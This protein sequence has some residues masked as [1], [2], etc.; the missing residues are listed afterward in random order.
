MEAMERDAIEQK[1]QDEKTIDSLK[2]T[3]EGLNKT[4]EEHTV[5]HQRYDKKI[6]LKEEGFDYMAKDFKVKVDQNHDLN[7]QTRANYEKIIETMDQQLQEAE[8]VC[9]QKIKP[10]EE[11]SERHELQIRNLKDKLAEASEEQK[12]LRQREAELTEELEKTKKTAA[13]AIEDAQIENYKLSRKMEKI[14]Q[15]HEE[16]APVKNVVILEMKLNEVINQTQ[17][18]LKKRDVELQ[19][20]TEIINNLQKAVRAAKLKE[21]EFEDL[22]NDRVQQKEEGYGNVVAQL[23]FAEGQIEQERGRTTKALQVV[24]KREKS[25]DRLKAEH[26]E[27]LQ[28]RVAEREAAMKLLVEENDRW[29]ETVD[30]LEA[31]REATER[32][33]EAIL[34]DR[35]KR[36]ADREADLHIE[37]LHRDEVVAEMEESIKVNRAHFDKQRLSWEEKERE[38]QVMIRARDRSITGLKNEIEFIHES[39]ELKYNRLMELFEKLQQK[40]EAGIGHQGIMETVRRAAALKEENEELNTQIK[41]LKEGLK[42][43][44]KQIRDL[45]VDVDMVTKETADIL[46]DKD[47]AM[48]ELVGENVNLSS[49]LQASIDEREAMIREM[50]SEMVQQGESFQA[51]M[52]QL[53]QLAE[54]M[55]FTDRQLLIDKIDVWKRAY[56]RVAI[57]RDDQ[58]EEFKETIDIK[59]KQLGK[60]AEEYK[61]ILLEIDRVKAQAEEDLEALEKEWKE[62]EKS[63]KADKGKLL[64]EIQALKAQMEKD[65]KKQ[66]VTQGLISQVKAADSNELDNLKAK[67]ERQRVKKKALKAG[68]QELINENT[69]WRKKC[70]ELEEMLTASKQD[71][72]K[73]TKWRDDRYEAMMKEHEALKKVLESE[74]STAQDT[75][76]E[77]EEQVRLFPSPFEIELQELKD[78]YAQTQAGMLQMSLENTR[79]QEKLKDQQEAA[80]KEVDD[81][82]ANLKLAHYLLSEVGSVGD[83]KKIAASRPNTGAAES[84]GKAT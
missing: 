58:E 3:V 44:K 59:D 74:M 18:L 65:S 83:L 22:W 28:H 36:Q 55:R 71:L 72:D 30:K 16:S 23:K 60:I 63:W 80:Q 45:Q 48:S 39:W 27:E 33:W 9:R 42:K 41:Q 26:A 2:L 8:R 78:R 54:A 35:I 10:W 5:E 68:V 14:I 64:Q 6:E 82:E 20:K 79:L 11:L 15:E 43:Q 73:L 46:A 32:K 34:Q 56:E 70:D 77:V 13:G 29:A 1:R 52:E 37:M 38:L 49:K 69:D 66:A 61:E 24:R 40:F 84:I 57:S 7:A 21:K 62:H 51:R 53:E 17:L 31:E 50:K 47:K 12:E 4:I 81:L 19:E 25:I 76:K 75:C 67:V